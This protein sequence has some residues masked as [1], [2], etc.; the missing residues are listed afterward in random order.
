MFFFKK[1]SEIPG[2]LHN[3]LFNYGRQKMSNKEGKLI[4]L[5]ATSNGTQSYTRTVSEDDVID[6]WNQVE[7]LG[8]TIQRYWP[9]TEARVTLDITPPRAYLEAFQDIGPYEVIEAIIA[10]QGLKVAEDRY[11]SENFSEFYRE[12]I[13]NR[14]EVSRTQT[15][16]L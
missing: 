12:C 7:D 3:L 13:I 8:D 1:G 9:E 16:S 5:F 14:K 6:I 2:V 10:Q 15:I 11:L 4:L